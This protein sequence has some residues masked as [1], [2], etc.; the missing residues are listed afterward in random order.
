[1]LSYEFYAQPRLIT[2]FDKTRCFETLIN[3]DAEDFPA[4]YK[5][6]ISI[7][8]NPELQ[9]W[10]FWNVKDKKFQELDRGL[11]RYFVLVTIPAPGTYTIVVKDRI[12]PL[13]IEIE[14]SNK[15]I[16]T[17]TYSHCATH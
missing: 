12:H 11:A 8:G 14:V 3:Y 15:Q 13:L 16:L 1:M 5:F 17:K 6:P 10:V 4:H 9:S 7:N 2:Q